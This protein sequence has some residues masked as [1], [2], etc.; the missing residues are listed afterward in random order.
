MEKKLPEDLT[1]LLTPEAVRGRTTRIMFQDEARF[2]R[3]VRI[4]SC[5]APGTSRPK[6]DN[7]YVRQFVYVYEAVSPLEGELDWKFG[8]TMKT[9]QMN[10]FLMQVSQAHPEEFMVMIVD[11]ASS[12]RSKDLQVPENIRLHRLPGYS[13]ELNPQEHVWDEL[14]EKEFPNRVFES[15]DLVV[16]QL[17]AGLPRLAANTQALRSLT[18]W[19]CILSL[20][21]IEK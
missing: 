9:E 10:E 14:R 8:M 19:P 5:W 15:M 6:V 21:L 4:R 11:G 2:G 20:T 16:G 13:P 3:M 17:E 7:G 12:H 18:A 1:A